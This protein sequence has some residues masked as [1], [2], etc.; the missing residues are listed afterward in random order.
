MYGDLH[1]RQHTTKTDGETI[2]A[3]TQDT[4]KKGEHQLPGSAIDQTQVKHP[5]WIVQ[6]PFYP[7]RYI[8]D[9]QYLLGEVTSE[10]ERWVAFMQNIEYFYQ[11]R[12]PYYSPVFQSHSVLAIQTLINIKYGEVLH[13]GIW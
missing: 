2:T 12:S 8:S 11:L 10:N 7:M 3:G 5:L 13:V 9:G 6:A 4:F 1:R